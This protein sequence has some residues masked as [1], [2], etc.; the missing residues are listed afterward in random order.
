MEAKM[1]IKARTAALLLTALFILAALSGCA[2]AKHEPITDEL[3]GILEQNPAIK[4]ML[5]ES[6]AMA[7]ETNPDKDTNPAQTLEE[8][9]DF[10]DWSVKAMPW[11]VLNNAEYP[12]IYDQIDQSVCYFYFI[13]DQPLAALLGKGY[14][15]NSLQYVP[16]LQPW[17]V[18]YC[19]AWGAYLSTE[20]SWNDEYYGLMLKEPR[21]NLDIGWYEDS[22][23]WKTWNDFFARR[24]S[25]PAVRPIMSAE[26]DSI[27][28]APA[29]S[30]PQGVWQ[31]DENSQIVSEVQIKSTQFL[32]VAQLLG[33]SEYKDAFAGGVLTHT[34]LNVDDYHR[35]HFPVSG[36]VKE[37]NIIPAQDAAGGI[38]VWDASTGRYILYSSE[39]GW[40]AIETRGCVII[41][42]KEYGYVAVLPV[43]MSQISSVVFDETVKVG[44]EAKKG[45]MLGWFLFGGS[46]VVMLFEKQAGFE[47]LV[48]GSSGGYSHVL[49]GED[50]GSLK[51]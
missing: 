15:Y 46:D 3:I 51:K 21:F 22:S 10:L 20:E 38:T 11:N 26:D 42:T 41:E 34:F 45:D 47:I 28:A 14:Y 12:A 32:S 4:E 50:Y 36:T 40:Q 25:S 16:E 18:N 30:E 39:P 19:K 27:V 1:K 7:K 17:I 37:V 8:Y 44:A 2:N 23:N 43:G 13:L 31:I 5:I 49:M 35:F 48:P 6:I 9:Y 29:D 24:L 33:N